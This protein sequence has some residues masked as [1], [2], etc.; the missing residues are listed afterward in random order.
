MDH[1]REKPSKTCM[2]A[3]TDI[4]ILGDLLV[5][6]VVKVHRFLHFLTTMVILNICITIFYF[7]KTEAAYKILLA[8]FVT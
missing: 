1:E 3:F 8:S 4:V 5:N 7:Q 2:Y 6:L